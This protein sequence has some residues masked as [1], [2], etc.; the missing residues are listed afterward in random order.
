MTILLALIHKLPNFLE[1]KQ[2][3]EMPLFVD[4]NKMQWYFVKLDHLTSQ[5]WSLHVYVILQHFNNVFKIQ[6]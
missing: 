1:M 4:Y 3:F 6:C 2:N 5:T